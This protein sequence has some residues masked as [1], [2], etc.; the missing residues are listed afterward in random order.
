MYYYNGAQRYGQFLHVSRLY[1]LCLAWFSS[2]SSEHLCVFDLMV[3]SVYIYIYTLCLKK[4]C[5]F[6]TVITL[7]NFG[8]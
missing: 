3:L 5:I 6:V 7:S 4:N 2:L 1:G 8:R